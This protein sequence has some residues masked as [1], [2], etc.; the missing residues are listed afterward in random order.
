MKRKARSGFGPESRMRRTSTPS[1]L[2]FAVS[3]SGAL[4]VFSTNEEGLRDT[5]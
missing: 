2:T 5:Q 4:G 1:I 3:G